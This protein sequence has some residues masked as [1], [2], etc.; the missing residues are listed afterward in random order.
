MVIEK[1][2]T[3]VIERGLAILQAKDAEKV[4]P[5]VPGIPTV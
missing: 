2:I 5:D 3:A 4:P 1:A